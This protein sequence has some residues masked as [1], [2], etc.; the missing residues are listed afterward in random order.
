MTANT[1]ITE[2]GRLIAEPAMSGYRKGM[3]TLP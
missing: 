2:R 1:R 3:D